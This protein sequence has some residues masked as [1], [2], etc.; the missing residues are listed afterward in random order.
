MSAEEED[1]TLMQRIAKILEVKLAFV[2]ELGWDELT[3]SRRSTLDLDVEEVCVVKPCTRLV[4]V[5]KKYVLIRQSSRV[6]EQTVAQAQSEKDK[7]GLHY[8]SE[9][10]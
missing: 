8:L 1:I 4:N 2:Q 10:K 6:H 9:I 5:S 7:Y 3:A